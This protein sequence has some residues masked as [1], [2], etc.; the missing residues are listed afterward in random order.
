MRSKLV[1]KVY[2]L[3]SCVLI[4]NTLLSQ[5]NYIDGKIYKSFYKGGT[6]GLISNCFSQ[7]KNYKSIDTTSLYQL[8]MKDLSV[9]DSMIASGN[10]IKIIPKKYSS[11]VY[12][13]EI[14]SKSSK[15][16]FLFI[17]PNIFIDFTNKR[18]YIVPYNSFFFNI[19]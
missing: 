12:A 17:S 7:P 5:V 10:S 18:K 19:K 16:H 4:K 9:I 11:I 14:Y 15:I 8:N 13:G 1:I 2:L 3:L 6:S